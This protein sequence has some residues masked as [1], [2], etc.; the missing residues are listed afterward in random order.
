[1]FNF[2]KKLFTKEKEKVIE[3]PNEYYVVKEEENL[4]GITIYK[5]IT[6]KNLIS[7][8]DGDTFRANL[9]MPCDILSNNIPIR[10]YGID[11]PEIRNKNLELKELGMRA[12]DYLKKRLEGGNRIELR[13][14]RRGMYFR[15]IAEVYIDGMSIGDELLSL[16]FARRYY[17]GSKRGLWDSI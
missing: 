16:K 9:H 13:N 10:I 6:V 5:D 17:G 12:R 1:M 3:I 14:I 8:Y 11:T 2:I 15:I 4:R 7:V